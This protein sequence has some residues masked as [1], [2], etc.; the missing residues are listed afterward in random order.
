MPLWLQADNMLLLYIH[1]SSCQVMV[2][3]LKFWQL[4][5]H[6][7]CSSKCLYFRGMIHA[8][9]NMF[10]LCHNSMES[11]GSFAGNPV[12]HQGDNREPIMD[13]KLR[14]MKERPLINCFLNMAMGFIAALRSSQKALCLTFICH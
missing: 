12:T 11:D 3:R 8:M 9:A 4:Q 2:I 7:E 13:T 10:C 5:H 6:Q 1:M 14:E